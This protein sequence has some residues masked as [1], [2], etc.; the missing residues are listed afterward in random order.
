MNKCY[1]NTNTQYIPVYIAHIFWEVAIFFFP[2]LNLLKMFCTKEE[3]AQGSLDS[4]WLQGFRLFLT[5][6]H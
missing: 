1:I 3:S 5:I 4:T 2:R 6:A